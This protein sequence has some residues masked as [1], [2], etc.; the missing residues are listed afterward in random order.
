[1]QRGAESR[2]RLVLS[3]KGHR[4]PLKSEGHVCMSGRP[5]ESPGNRPWR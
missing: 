3:T 5:G 4:G 1:M 2:E